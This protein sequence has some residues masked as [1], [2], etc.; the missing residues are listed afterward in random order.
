MKKKNILNSVMQMAGGLA[1]GAV[2]LSSCSAEPDDSN[3]YTFTGFTVA[4]Y[5]EQNANLSSFN[6]IVKQAN[7]DRILS[8]YGSYT[9]FAP[10]NAAIDKYLDSLYNDATK[11]VENPHNGM[12]APGLNGILTGSAKADSLC[13]DIV[14]FH[15]A[16]GSRTDATSITTMDLTDKKNIPTL[17]GRSIIVH[18][19]SLSIHGPYLNKPWVWI[20]NLSNP[21]EEKTAVNGIIHVISSVIPRENDVVATRLRKAG[22]FSIFSEALERTGLAD[23][24]T[25]TKKDMTYEKCNQVS[26]HWCLPEDFE[27]KVQYTIFAEPDEVLKANGI[28]SFDDLVAYANSKY[29][30]AQTWYDYMNLTDDKQARQPLG[31]TVNT[32]TTD[33]DFKLRN[34]ALNMFVAYHLMPFGLA[35]HVLTTEFCVVPAGRHGWTGDAY[36]YYATMLPNT[37]VKA[38]YV[39]KDKKVYLNRYI[40][41]NTLTDGLETVGSASMHGVIYAGNEVDIDNVEN[42][43]NGYLY[44]LKDMLVYDSQVKNGV[45]RERIRIDWLSVLPEIMNNDFR[46][47]RTREIASR[48]GANTGTRIRF[49]NNFFDYVRVY[50]SSNT[51]LGMN[52]RVN[53][54]DKSYSLYQGDSFR[55]SGTADFAIKL[56]PVPEGDYELRVDF[57]LATHFGMV[58]YYIGRTN[59][60]N[61]MEALDI[62]MDCRMDYDDPRVGWTNALEEE[63]YDIDKGFTT[64]KDMRNRGWLRGALSMVRQNERT[65]ESFYVRFTTHQIRRILT[66]RHFDQG[67]YWLRVKSVLPN[68]PDAVF[69]LDYVEFVPLDVV[70]NAT[71]L[72]DMY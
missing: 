50:N 23:S 17:L 53:D 3:L 43:L 71:Y 63:N 69:Q 47:A 66:K 24:L 59:D 41:N 2:M 38:W 34:N 16:G 1:V 37:L 22:R 48:D 64:D 49:P 20:E 32:G 55:G 15:L 33:A 46:G 45:L 6:Q 13:A 14:K 9:C 35:P 62:P 58:Q 5:L 19:D 29:N 67:D 31:H 54:G 8:S 18:L 40:A 51:N 56:P 60:P 28:N 10:T 42:P 11:E 21:T 25:K 12:D 36:D 27:S 39:N 72:E 57:T 26:D 68:Y 61:D 7:Y 4:E 65:N 30:N 52:V 44:P 70:Q